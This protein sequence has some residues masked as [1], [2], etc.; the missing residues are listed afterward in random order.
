V[1][2]LQLLREK[3]LVEALD[4]LANECDKL[5][6]RF[7]LFTAEKVDRFLPPIIHHQLP[8]AARFLARS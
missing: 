7:A 1:S 4:I 6:A 3:N 5:L 2:L 8:A